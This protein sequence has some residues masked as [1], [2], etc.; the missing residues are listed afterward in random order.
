MH[1]HYINLWIT[2]IYLI[3]KVLISTF[4]AVIESNADI[5]GEEFIDISELPINEES[6]GQSE[7]R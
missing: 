5:S 6:I 3:T 1:L 7:A 2:P 4:S